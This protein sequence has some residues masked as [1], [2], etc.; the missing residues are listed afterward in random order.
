MHL[1]VLILTKNEEHNLPFALASLSGLQADVFVVDS[2]SSDRTIEIALAAGC[3]VVEHDFTTHARQVNWA[4]DNL[5][6]ASDWVMRLDADEWLTPEL[7]AELREKLTHLPPEVT[8]LMVRRRVYFWGRWI[9]HG[10]YYP[11]WLLRVWRLGAARSDDRDM[12]E[13]MLVRRGRIARLD[14]DIVDENRNGLGAWI[15][16]HNLYA[17]KEAATLSRGGGE[18]D[19][20][21]AGHT[22]ARRRFLRNT[23]YGNS[24]RYWR[25]F[26]YWIFRYIFQLGFLDGRA[27]LV[28][29]FL[30]AF[31]YRLLVDAKLTELERDAG[32]RRSC[33]DARRLADDVPAE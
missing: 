28:F 32:R 33:G 21:H 3:R 29:H 5:P 7:V 20:A 8:G 16:K 9:R 22:V 1:S 19:I 10:G 17:E 18:T 2:G 14:H 25:A 27:G 30:Q 31:W 24:P 11:T 23:V 4:L 26:L 15:D 6:I 13:H 12:D